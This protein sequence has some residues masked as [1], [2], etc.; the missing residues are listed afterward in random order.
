MYLPFFLIYD[1]SF[2]ILKVNTVSAGFDAAAGDPLGGCLVSPA[3]YAH[4]TYM[5]CGLAGGRVAVALEVV[6]ALSYSEV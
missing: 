1:Q 2:L 4:M 5:L 6:P 3:G